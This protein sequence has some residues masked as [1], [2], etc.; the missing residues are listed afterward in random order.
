MKNVTIYST[1][2]CGWCR[3]AKQFFQHYNVE[4]K[5]IDVAGDQAALKEMVQK[6]GQMGVPVIDVEGDIIV[7]FNQPKLMELLELSQ[8]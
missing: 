3:I 2:T 7:G 4:F 6:S 8:A 5:E 1:P